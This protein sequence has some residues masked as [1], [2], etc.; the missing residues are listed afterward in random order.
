VS[1]DVPE[2][3]TPAGPAAKRSRAKR[4]A[5]GAG[6]VALVVVVVAGLAIHRHREYAK[7]LRTEPD[8][9]AADPA[10]VRFATAQAKPIYQRECASCHGADMKGDPA[11][12]VPSLADNDWLYGEGRVPEIEKTIL[13]GIRS[14]HP[15]TWN[16]AEM[17]GFGKPVPA[18]TY[19]T[20]PLQP[21]EIR[22]LVDYLRFLADKPADK[23]AA[24]RGVK[25]F[26]DRGQ[27]FDCHG[28]DARGDPAIGAPNLIDDIWLYG[29]GS[30]QSV[31]DSIAHGHHGACP[32]WT[33][34]LSAGEIRALAVYLH[35]VSS[36][37]A[38]AGVRAASADPLQREARS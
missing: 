4:W 13:Y 12:G 14:G 26:S 28:E 30:P 17:P 29:D 34:R 6:L 37:A 27:C 21:Q 18:A 20:Q 7:L 2:G 32:A 35:T 23:E 5:L 16:L 22:D 9:E 10:L 11:R 19:K 3:E 15:K 8:V 33:R 36:R 1:R 25:L 31:Y 24:T 38:A